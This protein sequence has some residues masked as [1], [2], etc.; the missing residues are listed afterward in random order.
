MTVDLFSV[1]SA[2]GSAARSSIYLVNVSSPEAERLALL[3]R[4][5]WQ[6]GRDELAIVARD[7][8]DALSHIR[9]RMLLDILPLDRAEMGLA[10]AAKRLDELTEA[11]GIGSEDSKRAEEASA[12]LR[13][14]LGME[15]PL[16]EPTISLLLDSPEDERV[17]VMSSRLAAETYQYLAAAGA[18]ASV[19]LEAAVRKQAVVPSMVAVGP[20]RFFSAALRT[21]ARANSL[22]FVQFGFEHREVEPGGI[23]GDEGG[24]QT[25]AV[26]ASGSGR[27]NLS[28]EPFDATEAR[29]AA[30]DRIAETWA[31]VGGE[32][33]EAMLIVLHDGFAV[34]TET[35]KENWMQ[36]VDDGGQRPVLVNRKASELQPGDILV[37][38]VDGAESDFIRE[39]ADEQFGASAYRPAQ[40]A[41]KAALRK[42]INEA[43]G[44]AR[45]SQDLQ[46]LGVRANNLPYW[47]GKRCISPKLQSDFLGVARYTGTLP[48]TALDQWESLQKIHTAHNRAGTHVRRELEAMLLSSGTSQLDRT[49]HQSYEIEMCGQLDAFRIQLVSDRIR[50]VSASRIDRPFKIQESLWR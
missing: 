31:D 24:L 38:R 23:F 10:A 13:S 32:P 22:C 28:L 34:W 14:L 41:W 35:D 9:Y 40:A 42:K 11:L 5:F 18:P 2:Y 48:E 29:R 49:G 43:G 25:P 15:N 36:C 47:T 8:H 37:L 1:D 21:A 46:G 17:L 20:P 27:L 4:H 50:L 7:A 19:V 6:A 26:R 16:A 33:V 44:F 12:L 45:A 39:I 3:E 30:A